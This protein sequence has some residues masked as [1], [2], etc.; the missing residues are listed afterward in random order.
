MCSDLIDTGSKLYNSTTKDSKVEFL[1]IRWIKIYI[2]AF[3]EE[4]VKYF[5]K[6]LFTTITN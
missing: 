6:F 5:V 1:W 4:C 3:E 2:Y